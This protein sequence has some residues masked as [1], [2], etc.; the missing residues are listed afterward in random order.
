MT[1]LT[2]RD[3][4]PDGETRTLLALLSVYRRDGRATV[5]TVAAERGD[6]RSISTIHG[7]LASLAESGLVASERWKSGTLRPL[8]EVVPWPAR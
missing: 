7:N 4:V 1:A 8:V 6:L 2:P 3:A 5:R